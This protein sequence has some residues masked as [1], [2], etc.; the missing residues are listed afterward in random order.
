M[1][2]IHSKYIEIPINNRVNNVDLVYRNQK[3]KITAYKPFVKKIGVQ[4]SSR[5]IDQ[6]LDNYDQILE[7]FSF[8]IITGNECYFDMYNRSGR[9]EGEPILTK[10]EFLDKL[11]IFHIVIDENDENNFTGD[12]SFNSWATLYISTKGM[13]GSGVVDLEIYKTGQL[14]RSQQ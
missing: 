12:V 1:K 9:Y 2:I 10:E 7:D 11:S 3:I 6:I 13:I 14:M 4:E 8:T 5:M